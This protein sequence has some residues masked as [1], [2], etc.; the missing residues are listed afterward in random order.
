MNDED[1]AARA[2]VDEDEEEHRAAVRAA[3]NDDAAVLAAKLLRFFVGVVV[4]VDVVAGRFDIAWVM[5]LRETS[6]TNGAEI[7]ALVHLSLMRELRE[8][9]ELVVVVVVELRER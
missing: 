3:M 7:E 8:R 5:L 2:A 6:L 9:E 4:V 1:E